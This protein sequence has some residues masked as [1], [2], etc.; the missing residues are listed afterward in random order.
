MA[1]TIQ[2]APATPGEKFDEKSPTVQ[3]QVHE[4]ADRYEFQTVLGAGSSASVWK[5]FDKKD[6]RDVA[7]KEFSDWE[8]GVSQFEREVSTLKALNKLDMEGEYILRMLDSFVNHNG[9]SCIVM[10]V[11]MKER[12][13][14]PEG[15]DKM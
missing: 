8:G 15:I 4:G 12:E 5:A 1:S 2:S 7:I 6:T 10:E 3:P 11:S 13:S 9:R 14:A